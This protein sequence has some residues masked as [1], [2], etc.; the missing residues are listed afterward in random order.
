MLCARKLV[1]DATY[2]HQQESRGRRPRGQVLHFS[3]RVCISI[4]VSEDLKVG[5]LL[6]TLNVK[7]LNACMLWEGLLLGRR[8]SF[9]LKLFFHVLT[10]PLV[11]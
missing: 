7:Y 8:F 5:V 2:R 3:P 1:G 10:L 6:S 4:C 9:I 11:F